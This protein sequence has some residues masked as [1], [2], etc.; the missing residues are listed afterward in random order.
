MIRLGG[1]LAL[2]A[3]LTL[4][5][6]LALRVHETRIAGQVLEVKIDACIVDVPSNG[7]TVPEFP[8]TMPP[9]LEAAFWT[10]GG[11]SLPQARLRFRIP[12]GLFVH[13]SAGAAVELTHAYLSLPWTGPVAGGRTVLTVGPGTWSVGPW[14]LRGVVAGLALAP[15]LLWAVASIPFV[16]ARKRAGA[17]A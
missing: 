4:G 15:L 9:Q 2:L 10:G 7:F 17:Q 1:V 13:A 14:R 16:V 12:E 6:F 11:R 8:P 5:G 3:S